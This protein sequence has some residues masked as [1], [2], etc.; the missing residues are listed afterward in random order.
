[1]K[2]YDQ[3]KT[4][5]LYEVLNKF[6]LIMIHEWEPVFLDQGCPNSV[7]EGRCPAEFSSNLPQHMHMPC[8]HGRF[9]Y[10]Y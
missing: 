5:L 10:A 1:M 4:F 7:P 9:Y 8:M 2:L 3:F 6:I